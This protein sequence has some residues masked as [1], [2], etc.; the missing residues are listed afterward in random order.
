[1]S[2][3]LNIAIA[4]H[5]G[6]ERWSQFKTLQAEMAIRGAIFEAKRIAGLQND[7]IS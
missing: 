3:L 7:V 1:M 2:D 4:A 6:L 5:G